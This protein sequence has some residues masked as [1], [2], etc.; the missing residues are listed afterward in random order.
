MD[1]RGDDWSEETLMQIEEYGGLFWSLRK[2]A[3]VI[4]VE[5]SLLKASFED[6]G[7]IY[8]RYMKGL[9]ISELQLRKSIFEHAKAGSSPAQQMAIKMMREAESSEEEDE[10]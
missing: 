4:E 9:L 2:I 6:E 8:K 10:I 5:Y 7:I 3:I 1:A